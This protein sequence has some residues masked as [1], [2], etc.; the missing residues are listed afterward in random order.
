MNSNSFQSIV[1]DKKGNIW[2]G[3]RVAEKD[4]PNLDK[5]YGKGGLNK[6][7]GSKFVQFPEMKGLNESDVFSIY[8]D[9]SNDLWISTISNRV[10]NYTDNGFLNYNV[11]TSTMAFFKT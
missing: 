1:E 6:Y 2:I 8:K 9:I 5:R 4:N 3:T 11:P 7:N 10:Y